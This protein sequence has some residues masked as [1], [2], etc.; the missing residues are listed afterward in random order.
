MDYV[1]IPILFL[2]SLGDIIFF[3]VQKLPDLQ[4]WALVMRN[5]IQR[6]F[7]DFHYVSGSGIWVGMQQG[8]Y[9]SLRESDNSKQMYEYNG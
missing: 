7:V 6:V 4:I 2:G 8:D 5:S 1:L 9:T 3:D